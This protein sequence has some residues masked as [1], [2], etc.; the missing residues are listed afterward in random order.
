MAG[1]PATG[2]STIAQ[3]LAC[4]LPAVLLNKDSIRAALFPPSEIEY[5][6]QQDDL[7][8]RVVLLVAEDILRRNRKKR[9]LVDG[10]PFSRRYQVMECAEIAQK[11]G[12]PLKLVHCVCSDETARRRLERDTQD[13]SHV[14][15][16]R[17]FA[18]YQTLKAHFEPI[19]VEKL[20]VNT[21]EDVETCVQL[22]LAYL[23]SVSR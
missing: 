17:G 21:D 13:G 10:R 20:V 16:N 18:L 12:V 1:L 23:G 4:E 15:T 5:S 8:M 3:W 2:K 9:V 14:A 6:V 7:C 11:L 19:A 22:C